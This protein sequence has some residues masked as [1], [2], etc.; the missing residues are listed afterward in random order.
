MAETGQARVQDLETQVQDLETQVKELETQLKGKQN[1]TVSDID[2][3]AFIGLTEKEILQ[4]EESL[5]EAKWREKLKRIEKQQLVEF[6]REERKQEDK[7]NRDINALFNRTSQTVEKINVS[8]RGLEELREKISEIE[9][10]LLTRWGPFREMRKA[11]ELKKANVIREVPVTDQLDGGTPLV[12][13]INTEMGIGEGEDEDL[14]AKGFIRLPIYAQD[15][16]A[17]VKRAAGRPVRASW[18]EWI[19]LAGIPEPR[20]IKAREELT[21]NLEVLREK[22]GIVYEEEGDTLVI[23]DNTQEEAGR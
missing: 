6:Y 20:I 19:R 15:I 12:K 13:T 9:R 2:L 18:D 23:R 21:K 4:L 22:G 7:I 10:S 8:F 11:M 16:L 14:W 17:E 1:K 3:T 5:K